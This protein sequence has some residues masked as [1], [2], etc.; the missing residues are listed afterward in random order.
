MSHYQETPSAPEIK[1]TANQQMYHAN[2]LKILN[3]ALRGLGQ[4][5]ESE[6]GARF[7]RD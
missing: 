7:I 1:G 6:G 5:R 4:D 2:G 3:S